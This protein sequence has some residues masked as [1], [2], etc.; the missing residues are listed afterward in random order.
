MNS[1]GNTVQKSN[2]GSNTIPIFK[3]LYRVIAIKTAWYW[4]KN[5][6]E[7]QRNKIEDPDMHPYRYAHLNLTKVTKTYDGEKI[8][9][10]TSIGG[11]SAY[12]PAEN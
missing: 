4:Y 3:P 2:A 6:Y 9:F 10:S 7:D 5:R 8:A 12:L 1:L 11:K